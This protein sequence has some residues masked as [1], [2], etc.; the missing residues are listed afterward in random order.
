MID[1][2]NPADLDRFASFIGARVTKAEPGFAEARLEITERH[3]NGIGIVQ[4]GVTYT[5]ADFT[6]AAASNAGGKTVIGVQSDTTYFKPPKGKILRAE[7]KEVSS[8]RKICNYC[9]DVY[10]EQGTYV[11]RM[12][13]MGYIKD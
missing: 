10:D 1:G 3:L 2:K 4:G 7:A 8:S 9:I 13:A 5:L 6:F 11:A 12:S